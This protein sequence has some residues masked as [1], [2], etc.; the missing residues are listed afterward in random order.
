MVEIRRCLAMLDSKGRRQ[1]RW[2]VLLIIINSVLELASVGMILPF[3]AV[4]NDPSLVVTQ[5]AVHAVYAFLGFE[6]PRTF[7]IFIGLSILGLILFKN[8]YFFF[9]ARSQARFCHFQAARSA[10]HL[11]NGYLHAPYEVHLGRNSASFI[12]TVDHAVD[13]QTMFLWIDNGYTGV[14]SFEV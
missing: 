7:L 12:N 6:S 9:V 13:Q 11:L 8:V 5:P 14:M 4:L 10:E 1:L 3:I 2:L